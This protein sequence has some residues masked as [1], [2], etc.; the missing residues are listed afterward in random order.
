MRFIK[1]GLFLALT[2]CN[3]KNT[4][5]KQ[6][7]TEP[8]EIK[9]ITE[10]NY[11]GSKTGYANL[12]EESKE[13]KSSRELIFI[14]HVGR[15]GSRYMTKAK[16][17]YA[18]LAFLKDAKSKNA[19]SPKGERL[20]R[21]TEALYKVQKTEYGNLTPT[22]IR[23]QKAIAKRTKKRFPKLFSKLQTEQKKIETVSTF[24]TRTDQSRNAFVEA[25]IENDSTLG[26]LIS[27]KKYTEE[28]DSVL[29]FF[30]LSPS[31]IAYDENSIWE[32]K[33]D[34]LKANQ[35]SF[36]LAK[37]VIKPLISDAM[38]SNLN[39]GE[40]EYKSE[41]GK[42]IIKDVFSAALS[43]YKMHQIAAGLE[44][45]KGFNDFLTDEQEQYFE[46]FSDYKTFMAEG[47]GDG[48]NNITTIIAYP[49]LND[50][51]KTTED[52]IQNPE[53]ENIARFRFA[54]A[55]TMIPFISLMEIRNFSEKDQNYT[56]KNTKRW[57]ASKVSPMSA[58]L[59]ILVY[60][61][62]KNQSSIKILHNEI[63]VSIPIEKDDQGY[64]AWSKFKNYY[65]S[66]LS[67]A[68]YGTK[69]N[70]IKNL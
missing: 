32:T 64:Y 20:L 51:I 52:A 8:I 59:M 28:A 21:K 3:S 5:V 1:I 38:F 69:F 55:E 18:T 23:E 17:D 67:E 36:N 53:Q 41:G 49:L 68:G 25:L 66:K 70:S 46:F 26:K 61:D 48:K 43:I 35:K 29:R 44:K 24:K 16:Y 45:I 2:A 6:A 39:E 11:L 19:L 37:S 47:P 40:L 58:N 42:T 50:F 7:S 22:G 62:K 31:Y 54:H 27:R 13:Y 56:L 57:K 10:K 60:K 15:H 33:L 63:E 34:E 14:N 4:K 9:K 30:D 65:E 12:S